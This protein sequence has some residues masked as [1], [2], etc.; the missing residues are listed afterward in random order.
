MVAAP[1]P[2]WPVV[3]QQGPVRLRPLRLRDLAAWRE[4][5]I[6]NE[7]WLAHW[8]PTS[9]MSWSERHSRP[10][11]MAMRSQA[12]RAG[13]AGSALPF[14]ITVDDALVG[15][16]TVSPILGGAFRSGEVGYWIDQQQAGRGVV[17]LA[18]ALVVRHCFRVVG[19][20]RVSAAVRPENAPS[21]RVMEKLGF[22]REGLLERYLDIDGAWRDHVGFALTV[23]DQPPGLLS[24]L[25]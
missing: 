12:N 14:V 5:R 24:L 2:G 21:L 20:H 10:A 3:L 23:E 25:H 16:V 7:R 8:E 18:V 13:R 1:H 4:V 9:P 11:Y 17:P 6:R 15:Q 19:L 22:R